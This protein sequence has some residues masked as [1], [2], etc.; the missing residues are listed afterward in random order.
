MNQLIKIQLAVVVTPD[1]DEFFASCPALKGLH[2]D[3]A[4]EQDARENACAAAGV[5]LSSLIR[6]GDPLPI[7]L[8]VSKVREPFLDRVKH[9]LLPNRPMHTITTEVRSAT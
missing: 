3:G 8:D 7:G 1:G 5:Y 2:I 4:T 6:K 9:A